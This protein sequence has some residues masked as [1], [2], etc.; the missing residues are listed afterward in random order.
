VPPVSPGATETTQSL[1][2]DSGWK[3]RR[4]SA[5]KGQEPQ[6]NA[7]MKSVAN[8][9]LVVCLIASASLGCS[10]KT[11]TPG[12]VDVGVLEKTFDTADPASKAVVQK[13]VAE[14]K[15]ADYAGALADL[16]TLNR[17]ENISAEQKQAVNTAMRQIATLLPPP[18][19]PLAPMAPARH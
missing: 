9:F 1:A 10:E 19:S 7:Y 16:G 15:A 18:Q 4:C 3:R 2:L 12:K 17:S 6:A 11:Q 5:A 8:L 13:A 14:V